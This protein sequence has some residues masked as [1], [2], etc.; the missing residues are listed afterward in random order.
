MRNW[1]FYGINNGVKVV[2]AIKACKSPSRTNEYKQMM[3]LLDN[4]V[5][6]RV[7]YMSAKAWN[8]E[9]QYNK[10]NMDINLN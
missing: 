6:E 10:M 4:Y 8:E 2:H 1:I 5:Y 7:G 3:K 9:N